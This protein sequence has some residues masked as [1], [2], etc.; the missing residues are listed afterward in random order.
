[1]IET[2][3]KEAIQKIDLAWKSAAVAE[4]AKAYGTDFA[5]PVQNP[6]G[7]AV[8]AFAKLSESGISVSSAAYELAGTSR[9]LVTAAGAGQGI[10]HE[11]KT[12]ALLDEPAILQ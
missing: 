3:E 4:V 6:E 11:S 12:Y 7:K 2:E 8:V 1:M 5:V 9:Q 10:S